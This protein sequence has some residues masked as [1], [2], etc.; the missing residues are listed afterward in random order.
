[1]IPFHLRP[2]EIINEVNEFNAK[3]HHGIHTLSEIGDI[4]VGASE[5]E[6]VYHED[7]LVLYHFKPLAKKL[8]PVPI[9]I[10]YALVNR[11]YMADLQDGRS[12]I[13]GLLQAG[14]DVYLIDW[15]YPDAA[16][17]YLTLDDY[18]NGYIDRCVN[19]IRKQRSL[20]KI[21][22]LGIC[23]GGTFSLCYSSLH[24]DKVKNLITTVTPVDFQTKNDL[25]SR[26]VRHIDIDMVVDT[27][28]NVPG[29]L[30]NY[31]YLSLKPFRLMGQKYM[32][33][34]NLLQDKEQARNF[35]RM[36]KWIF[37]SP[38]Q[39]GEAFRQFIKQFYQQNG[40]VNSMVR[41]GEDTVNLKKVT[42]PVLNI[43]AAAD[44]LV[45]SDSSKALKKLIGT[46]DYT[47]LEFP[48]GHIGIYVSSKA[49]KLI[50]P[51]VGEWLAKR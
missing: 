44:H 29:E 13:Q 6:P 45:P 47:E 38:D 8:N 28:G 30:L 32:D 17:R 16:D 15:G 10:V 31:T 26:M 24:P 25:L 1:M 21:N 11:P 20:D 4:D 42:M 36:E 18:I 39:V 27:I 34:V 19:Y 12:M 33:L 2:D 40:L 41:I 5:K 43:F 48:G 7:K 23:Q 35:M 46:K 50:P 9:L 22:L 37:D 14:Q 51:S 49:Q 3:L